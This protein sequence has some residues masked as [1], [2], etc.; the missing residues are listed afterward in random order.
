[1]SLLSKQKTLSLLSLTVEECR[2]RL[3][4]LQ[5]SEDVGLARA[6]EVSLF[7]IPEIGSMARGTQWP[8]CS[9]YGP[10]SRA[11]NNSAIACRV[12]WNQLPELGKD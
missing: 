6:V 1:M 3:R 2:V 12:L 7:P 11:L 4:R 5:E 8:N 10:W 9:V